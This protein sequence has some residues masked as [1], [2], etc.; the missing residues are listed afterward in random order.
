M[1]A[2]QILERQTAAVVRVL[3]GSGARDI[4]VFGSL[5]RVD[6]DDASDIDLLIDLPDEPS[7][8]AELLTVLGLSE[9]LSSI[10]G[11]RVDVVTP[12]TLR[13]EVREAAL[14]EAVPL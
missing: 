8:G 13:T 14:A 7:V 1:T 11:A 12:R 2:R 4:R 9:E 5:A 10:L 3:E 6:E